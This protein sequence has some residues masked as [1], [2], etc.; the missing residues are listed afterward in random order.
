M[1]EPTTEEYDLKVFRR[2]TAELIDTIDA[3]LFS[4][5][6]LYFDPKR[7]AAFS[8]ILARWQRRVDELKAI[9]ED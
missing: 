3:V 9:V 2:G 8:A 7:Q 4:G 6:E 1:P 5:D